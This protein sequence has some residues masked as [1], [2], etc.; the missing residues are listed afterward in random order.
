MKKDTSISYEHFISQFYDS[1][2]LDFPSMAPVVGYVTRGL[3]LEKQHLGIDIATKYKEKVQS[4]LYGRVL[5]TG[6][7]EVFG[8]KTIC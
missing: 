1:H 7:N 8:K 4:P 3:Q 6:E 2:E 5:Y